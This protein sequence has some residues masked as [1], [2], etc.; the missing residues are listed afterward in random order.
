MSRS[1]PDSRAAES[2]TPARIEE[3]LISR[4]RA[5]ENAAFDELAR[6]AGGRL[7]A[8]ARRMLSNEEEARDAVQ[9]TFLNA[10]KSLDRFDGRAQLATWLHRICVNAC[11]MRLRTRRRRPESAIGELLP[12]FHDDGHQ[13]NPAGAWRP[14]SEG[15]IEAAEL[16]AMV[17]AKVEE[18]PESYREVLLLRDIE[19]L[20]TDETAELLGM[21]EANVKT[22]LHR[23]R[24]AL[25]ALL[26][27]YMSEGTR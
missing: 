24:Q 4:L 12:T 5:G 21:S 16:R 26:D 25:K 20:D 7:L 11:L 23:A 6:S 27:P 18:L 10:F 1:G 22:R 17:R 19:Q 2:S 14:L 15:D 13:R 8:V 3:A 9:E